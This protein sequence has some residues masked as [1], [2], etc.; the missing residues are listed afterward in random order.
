MSANEEILTPPSSPLPVGFTASYPQLVKKRPLGTLAG[1]HVL[2]SI[3]IQT[4]LLIVFQV[5]ALCYL[6]TRSW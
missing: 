1:I 4:I 5:G 3:V 6:S 2:L